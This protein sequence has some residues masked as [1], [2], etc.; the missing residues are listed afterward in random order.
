MGFA[1]L[2]NREIE[3]A[4]A[5]DDADAQLFYIFLLA[6]TMRQM[7]RWDEALELFNEYMR[8]LPKTSS[9][10]RHA[11][12]KADSQLFMYLVA[13]YANYAKGKATAAQ[14]ALSKLEKLRKDS[15]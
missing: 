2:C 12:T 9:S 7:E 3:A 10:K 14:D 6:E 8:L 13:A 1:A 15:F 5:G 4:A 11:K